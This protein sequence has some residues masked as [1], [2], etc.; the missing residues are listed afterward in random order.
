M[1]R[2]RKRK[3][4]GVLF[5][6]VLEDKLRCDQRGGREND[7]KRGGDDERGEEEVENE[8]AEEEEEE[9][10]EEEVTEDKIKLPLLQRLLA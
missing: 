3:S 9:M 4:C 1:S 7:R 5:H 2:R 8:G 6:S 10:K